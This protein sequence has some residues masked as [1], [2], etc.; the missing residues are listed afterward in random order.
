ML[1]VPVSIYNLSIFVL[2]VPV[3]IY[4]LCIFV[5]C[6]PGSTSSTTSGLAAPEPNDAEQRQAATDNLDGISIYQLSNM[7]LRQ[8]WIVTSEKQY[9]SI[10][11][12]CSFVGLSWCKCHLQCQRLSCVNC[13]RQVCRREESTPLWSSQ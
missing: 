9:L 4:N 3:S 5:L 11:R 10:H 1:C 7:Q 2:C 13:D 6:V 8:S 12:W